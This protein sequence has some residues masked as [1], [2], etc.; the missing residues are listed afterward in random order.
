VSEGGQ[1]RREQF[2]RASA[3]LEAHGVERN[4]ARAELRKLLHG[5]KSALLE[6]LLSHKG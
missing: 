3:S 4:R 5:E 1:Q 6:G 2:A